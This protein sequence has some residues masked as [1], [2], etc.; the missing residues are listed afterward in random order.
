[1]DARDRLAE[2]LAEG[3]D[4]WSSIAVTRGWRVTGS[5]T[6]IEAVMNAESNLGTEETQARMGLLARYIKHSENP[7]RDQV[8]TRV[9]LQGVGRRWP[10]A[11]LDNWLQLAGSTQE[12]TRAAFPQLK[13]RILNAGMDAVETLKWTHHFVRPLPLWEPADIQALE[14]TDNAEVRDAYWALQRQGLQRTKRVGGR[15]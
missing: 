12:F 13:E 8:I 5:T 4:P 9:L 11:A 15:S 3:A 14:R 6:L 7:E 2:A 1:M 10:M